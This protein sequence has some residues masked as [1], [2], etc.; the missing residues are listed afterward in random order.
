V[1]TDW[2]DADPDT[3]KPALLKLTQ[4]VIARTQ[5]ASR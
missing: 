3:L 4:T 5:T 1:G 2:S